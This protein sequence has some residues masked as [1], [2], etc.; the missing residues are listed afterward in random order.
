MK[1]F[2]SAASQRQ[3]GFSLLEVLISLLIFSIGLMGLAGLQIVA[4]KANQ[5][6]ML[7][8]IASEAAYG[9]LDQLRANPRGNFDVDA[10]KTALGGALPGGTGKICVTT[11]A[12]ATGGK[13]SPSITSAAKPS[14][15]TSWLTAG[16]LTVLPT[17]AA[18][19]RPSLKFLHVQVTWAQASVDDATGA[20]Q[21]LADSGD[22]VQQITV[23][24]Q[25]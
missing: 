6:A 19:E 4:M 9:V 2:S 1:T 13:T 12:N 24:G 8:S 14:S 20:K 25:L 21:W 7:R 17:G 22:N 5:N 18:V 3:S 10:W 23:T 16:T 11:A 15:C